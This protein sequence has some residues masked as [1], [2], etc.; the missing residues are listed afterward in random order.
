L[1]VSEVVS[2]FKTIEAA[3]GRLPSSQKFSSRTLDIDL[4]LYDDLVCQE[5][6]ELPRAEITE[7]AFVLQPLAEIAATRVHPLTGK[8]YQTLW[9][10][11]SKP[12]RLWVVELD[13]PPQV[14]Q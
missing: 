5:P 4:L 10:A 9:Q 6:V 1:P 8:N 7:N 12:Q 3:H 14:S 11:Y 2:L 13:W